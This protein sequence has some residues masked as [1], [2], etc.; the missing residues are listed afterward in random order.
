M[1]YVRNVWYYSHYHIKTGKLKASNK[2]RCEGKT[3]HKKVVIIVDSALGSVR[4]SDVIIELFKN[5]IKEG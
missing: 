1:H 2:L 5:I 4:F 3:V